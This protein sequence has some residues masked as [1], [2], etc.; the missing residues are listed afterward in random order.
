ML[1]RV[2]RGAFAV[3]TLLAVVATTTIACTSADDDRI[4]VVDDELVLYRGWSGSIDILANDTGPADVELEVC[5]FPPG[6][7]DGVNHDYT[8][9]AEILQANA[10]SQAAPGEREVTY[11]VCAGEERAEGT[12]RIIVRDLPEI[13]VQTTSRPG[14]L[15]VTNPADVPV[16]VEYGHPNDDAMRPDGNVRVPAGGSRTFE[17]QRTEIDWGATPAGGQEPFFSVDGRVSGIELPP[18]V[19]PL[20]GPRFPGAT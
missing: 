17:V 6:T 13:T 2:I 12:V 19:D 10:G 9:G 20:P 18:G 14:V 16:S 11:T 5:D 15:R 4:E 1:A 8:P 3:P 7:T